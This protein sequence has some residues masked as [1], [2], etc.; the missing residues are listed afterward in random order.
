MEKI[1]ENSVFSLL[2]AYKEQPLEKTLAKIF[3]ANQKSE[4]MQ[5]S[6]GTGERRWVMK[7]KATWMLADEAAVRK[8]FKRVLGDWL[9]EVYLPMVMQLNDSQRTFVDFA[10]QL[11][12]VAKLESA[13]FVVAIEQAKGEYST[14]KLSTATPILTKS[15]CALQSLDRVT[16]MLCEFLK[17]KQWLPKPAQDQEKELCYLP[18]HDMIDEFRIYVRNECVK[19]NQTPPAI[20][21]MSQRVLA[22]A[23]EE[24]GYDVV[25]PQNTRKVKVWLGTNVV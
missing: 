17:E 11:L 15:D 1:K 12:S 21:G 19:M 8:Y 23:L 9:K 16:K 14:V 25:R 13:E 3:L 20:R 5:V 2:S 22:Q 7:K 6:V 18:L 4:G 10:K 24:C